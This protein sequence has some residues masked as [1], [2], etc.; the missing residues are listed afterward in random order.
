VAFESGVPAEGVPGAQPL[1]SHQS[2][3]QAHLRTCVY[4]CLVGSTELLNEQP[5]AAESRIPFICFTDDAERCSRSWQ[6]RPISPLFELDS[7]RSQRAVKLCPHR[8]LP[9]F[10]VSLYIDNSVLLDRLPEELIAEHMAESDF[11]I[12]H[13]SFRETVL[14]E[15]LAVAAD[16]LDDQGRIFEQL[17]HYAVCCPEV[18]QDK[19]CWTGIL[20]RDHSNAAVRDMLELWFAH[21]QRYSRRDQ[22]SLNFVLRRSGLKPNVLPIDNHRSSYHSWPHKIPGQPAGR[23]HNPIAA[24]GTLSARLR[25]LE[26]AYASYRQHADA[27]I[28]AL[29]EDKQRATTNIQELTRKL[30]EAEALCCNLEIRLDQALGQTKGSH[31]KSMR[32]SA[33]PGAMPPES[34]GRRCE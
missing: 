30:Q 10:D 34:P 4:T 15:F 8:Y 18:L 25:E 7:V 27:Q 9:D 11:C 17:N 29:V 20:L 28:T 24:Y 12:F 21:V 23:I 3:G 22:L 5:L 19:P 13:H 26:N 32:Q 33:N 2:A 1:A 14:D 31:D 6:I 16:G